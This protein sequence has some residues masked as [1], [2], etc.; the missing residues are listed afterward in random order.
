MH[1]WRATDGGRRRCRGYSE[2]NQASEDEAL[3]A[4]CAATTL[5]TTALSA[6]DVETLA[7]RIHAA[8]ARAAFPFVRVAAATLPGDAARLTD[9]CADL[10]AAASG[11][12]LLLTDVEH[13]PAI[14]QDE[15][16]TRLQAT[17][18]PSCRVRRIAGT[19]ASLRERVADGT[20][21]ERLFYQLNIIH[22]VARNRAFSRHL[23][24]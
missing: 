6:A 22:V 4:Q 8:S 11:G 1:S 20:F 18:E 3:A 13:M 14:A 7:R 12:S 5:L 23:R 17:R 24:P 19:T 15:T 16:V 2:R 10:L 9:T 21:S